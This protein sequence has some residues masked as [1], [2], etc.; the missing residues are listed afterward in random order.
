MSQK[1]F[2]IAV[3]GAAGQIGYALLPR[4]AMGAITGTDRPIRLKLLEIPPVLPALQGV[5]ME[6]EDM[7]SPLLT[8]IVTTSDVEE[9]FGD[10]NLVLLVGGKPRGKGM[11]RKDLIRDNGPIFVGQGKAINKCAAKDVRIL[12]V[13]NPCNTN[14]LIAMHNAPDVPRDRWSAMMRLDHNRSIALLAAKAGAQNKDVDRITVW[15]NHSATQYPD[16]TNATIQ[17]KKLTEVISDKAWLQGEFIT[18]VQQRGKAII[19]AR[20]ASSA[21]SAA[22]AAIDH[23]K[24]WFQK[25]PANTWISSAVYSDGSYGMPEGLITGFP[26]RYDGEGNHQIVKGLELDEFSRARIKISIDELLEERDTV[27]DL[28]S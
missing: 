8:E 9:A 12:V 1:P 18:K 3:T 23:S 2:T 7:A 5:K 22:A 21:A 6:L 10:A 17:G 11:E 24:D 25:T 4:V 16:I 20:G 26:V 27:K 15:G 19:D 14:C 28:L 13:G